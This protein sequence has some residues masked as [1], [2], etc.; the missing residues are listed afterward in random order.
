MDMTMHS[1][2]IGR[3]TEIWLMPLTVNT[4]DEIELRGAVGARWMYLRVGVSLRNFVWRYV[5]TSK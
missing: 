1:S 5:V 3:S 4:N 2:S